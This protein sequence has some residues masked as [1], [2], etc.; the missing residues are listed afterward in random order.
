MHFSKILMVVGGLLLA[1][2]AAAAP[3]PVQIELSH[4]LDE[5]RAD[6][7]EPLVAHFN[8][9][10][11]DVHLTLVRRVEGGALKQLNL[12][13]REE[14]S[15]FVANKAK[16]KPLHEVMREAKQPL[17]AGKF[18]PELIV[19][20]LDG[21]GQLFALP[22]AFSTPVL[23]INRAAFRKAGLNPDLP[24]KTWAETQYAAGKLA[25]SGSR[26]PFTTSWPALVHIDNLSAWN[27]AE[28]S[29]AKGTLTFNGL[30]QIKHVAML[31]TWY[32]SKYFSYF[33]R[34]DEADRRFASGECAMLTSTS[35]IF[36]SLV[37]SNTLEAGVS[38]LPYHDD[39]RGAPQSTLADGASLWVASGLK[40]AE[41]KGVASF[42]R[43][44]LGPEVQINLTLAGGFLPMTPVARLAASSKLLNADLAGLHVAYSQIRG[45]PL[46][47]L[48]RVAQL[49]PVRAIVEEELETV[50]AN[51]KPAKEA[52]DNA[53]ARGNAVLH[54]MSGAAVATARKRVK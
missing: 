44:V 13:T 29:D 35:S 14:Y 50:W 16:F 23:Y 28:V 34:R 53:V 42:I 9:Q 46:T 32:K 33:G 15:R 5:E 10:Q 8:S 45:K 49:E 39:I 30:A 25:D 7:L 47:P 52:L 27:G 3:A 20:L 48:I 2:M 40:P 4:Q 24:P 41:T 51:K 11:K 17:D 12:V 31:A 18:A 37:E 26:C 6:R 43:Y 22:V 21:K 19:G 1:L 36:A 54:S 38:A